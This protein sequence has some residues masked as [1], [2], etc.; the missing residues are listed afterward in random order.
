SELSSGDAGIIHAKHFAAPSS[1]NS[2]RVSFSA[3]VGEGVT[4]G[5]QRLKAIRDSFV[6]SQTQIPA[7]AR[8]TRARAP[9]RMRFSQLFMR[10]PPSCGAPV[11]GRE[12]AQ[13]QQRDDP[14]GVDDHIPERLRPCEP[15]GRLHEAAFPEN[16]KKRQRESRCG[17]EE[18]EEHERGKRSR[19]AVTETRLDSRG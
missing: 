7:Y 11:T 18:E 12:H 3:R 1:P 2:T 17:K 4:Y 8:T 16:R 14:C 19:G 6:R 5:I 15:S 9:H 10:D 13:R